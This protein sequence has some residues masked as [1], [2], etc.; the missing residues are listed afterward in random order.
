MSV[1]IEQIVEAEIAARLRTELHPVVVDI[2]PDKEREPRYPNGAVL[3]AY[4]SSSFGAVRSFDDLVAQEEELVFDVTLLSRSL[5]DRTGIYPLMRAAKS[6]LLGFKPSH[7]GQLIL[8]DSRFVD[9]D[10][11]VWVWS[12]SFSTTTLTVATMPDETLP[13]LTRLT[14]KDNLGNTEVIPDENL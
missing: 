7:C 12:L 13:T 10:D 5:R 4:Q 14:L 2:L 3:V 11:M 9:R 1:L 8:K 6:A